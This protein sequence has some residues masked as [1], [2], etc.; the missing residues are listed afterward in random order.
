MFKNMGL[1]KKM[2]LGFGVIVALMLVAGFYSVREANALAQ[3]TEKLYKHPLAVSTSIRDVH[4]DI[5]AMHRSMKDVALAQSPQQMQAAEMNQDAAMNW[6]SWG[7]WGPW[8]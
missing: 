1:G 3:L 2:V 5:I 6:D 8:Y 7:P 4:A